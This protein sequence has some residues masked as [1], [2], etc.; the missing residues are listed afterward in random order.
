MRGVLSLT[1]APVIFSH[2]GAYALQ[3]HLRYVPDV[4]RGVEHNGGIVMATFINRFL[5]MEVL[6]SAR[7]SDVIDHISH[8][9]EVAGWKHVGVGGDYSGTPE[10]PIG[11]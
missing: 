6:D 10:V 9:A 3:R 1:C 5:N 8:T 2:S 11:L 7:I 4:L